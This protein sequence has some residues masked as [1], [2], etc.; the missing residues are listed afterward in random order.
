MKRGVTAE[1][2]FASKEM[3][4]AMMMEETKEQKD[5]CIFFLESTDWDL[6]AAIELLKSMN[7]SN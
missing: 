7:I 3:T 4:V 2:A 1:D 5:V 6:P